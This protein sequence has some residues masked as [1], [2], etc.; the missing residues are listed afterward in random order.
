[1]DGT[2]GSVVEV[3]GRGS[4]VQVQVSDYY[5]LVLFPPLFTDM[6]ETPGTCLAD[7]VFNKRYLFLLSMEKPKC[8]N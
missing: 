7:D 2:E 6:Y 8:C 4:G 3:K 1:M 5:L